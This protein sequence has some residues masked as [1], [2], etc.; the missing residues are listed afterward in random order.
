MELFVNE[1]VL[2]K[3]S[4]IYSNKHMKQFYSISAIKNGLFMVA[5]IGLSALFLNFNAQK[6]SVHI[7]PVFTPKVNGPAAQGVGDRTGSP[8]GGGQA[9]M[10]CHSGGSYSPTIEITVKDGDNLIV[11]SYL[12]GETYTL[13]YTVSAGSGSPSGYG[14]QS[15]LISISPGHEEAGIVNS[16]SSSNTQ[17]SD[18]GGHQYIEHLAASTSGIF[19][20]DWTAPAAGFGSIA[21]YGRGLAVNGTGNTS[22]DQ[23]TSSVVYSLSEAEIT[24]ISYTSDM[25]CKND[26][27]P[28]VSI[29]GEAG[30]SFSAS[31]EGLGI[32]ASS[33][34]IDIENSDSGNYMVSYDYGGSTAATFEL[35][36]SDFAEY[37]DIVMA[38]NSFVWIDGNTYTEDN[39]IASYV[40][41]EGA[42]NGCDSI[43]YLDLT[44]AF[45]DISVNQN[46]DSLTANL[47]DATYQWLDCNQDYQLIDG[48]TDR[49]YKATEIGNYA[50][51]ITSGTCVDTSDCVAVTTIGIEEVAFGSQFHVYPNPTVGKIIVD[52]SVEQKTIDYKVLSING[53]ILKEGQLKNIDQIELDIEQQPG[54]YFLE[55][56]NDE[57]QKAIVKLLKL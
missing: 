35:M 56:I 17:I 36:I 15:L 18:V 23:E 25:F 7:S 54:F 39:N 33:G 8:V 48:A 14:M 28:M 10:D 6:P 29:V 50:V 30:G 2:T 51:E 40:I 4:N 37:T 31:P 26:S 24:S 46:T 53:Q 9:C 55:L 41:E 20:A 32:G 38:C 13:E 45:M 42:F 11:D 5:F 57:G 16:V 52:L 34:V 21:V 3:N 43:V 1:S 22:G 44:M 47:G 12:P 49:Y 19:T 27:D